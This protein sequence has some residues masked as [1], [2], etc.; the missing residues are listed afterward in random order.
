MST[1][2]IGAGGP[3]RPRKRRTDT[4][5]VPISKTTRKPKQKRFPEF[6]RGLGSAVE[7]LPSGHLK[8]IRRQVV[9]PGQALN[10]AITRVGRHYDSAVFRFARDP[11]GE[12]VIKTFQA[13]TMPRLSGTRKSLDRDLA[14]GV[15]KLIDAEIL[16][17]GGARCRVVTKKPSD[18]SGT[19]SV[20]SGRYVVRRR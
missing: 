9:S 1:E 16:V 18:C 7:L 4:E 8:P 14:E 11:E 10:D 15:G 5:H 20:A 17:R 12:K 6:W 2:L 3:I 13:R 19:V